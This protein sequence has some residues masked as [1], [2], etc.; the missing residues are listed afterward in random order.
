[1]LAGGSTTTGV[2]RPSCSG[3][4]WSPGYKRPKCVAFAHALPKNPSGKILERDLRQ[5]Y[6]NL[7]EQ[8]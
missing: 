6:A 3:S 8:G 1:V 5:E 4:R 2:T 7:A